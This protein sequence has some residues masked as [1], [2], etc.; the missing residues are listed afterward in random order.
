MNA[1]VL[2][3]PWKILRWMNRLTND[4]NGFR[5]MKE[6]DAVE[7]VCIPYYLISLVGEH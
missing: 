7:Q 3:I 5:A 2:L 4:W 1:S 6:I